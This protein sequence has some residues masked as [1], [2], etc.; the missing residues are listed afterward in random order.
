MRLRVGVLHVAAMLVSVRV[1]GVMVM[2]MV[3]MTVLLN[4]CL[5]GWM[6]RLGAELK[7]LVL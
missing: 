2:M 7:E 5:R 3:R 6:S 4:E 1:V